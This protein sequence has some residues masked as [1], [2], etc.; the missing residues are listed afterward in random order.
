MSIQCGSNG[1]IMSL[2]I[3]I[4]LLRSHY[5]FVDKSTR[6]QIVFTG[7][8]CKESAMVSLCDDDKSE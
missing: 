1:R 4:E 6:E 5:F 8:A 7:R 3:E 2:Q